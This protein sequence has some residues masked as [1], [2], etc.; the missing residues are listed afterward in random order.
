MALRFRAPGLRGSLI[1][2]WV[3]GVEGVEAAGSAG[4][5]FMA[6]LAFECGELECNH[7]AFYLLSTFWEAWGL[8]RAGIHK[9]CLH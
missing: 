2:A 6:G 9:P 3:C 8:A 7:S 1:K 4:V 5:G